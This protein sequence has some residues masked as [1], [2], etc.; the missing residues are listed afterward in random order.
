MRY[1]LLALT[2]VLA[3][4]ASANGEINVLTDLDTPFPPG[5]VAVSLPQQPAPGGDMLF[6][7]DIFVPSVDDQSPAARVRVNIWRTG[8][9]DAGYSVVMVRLAQ[10]QRWPGARAA[11]V[12]RGRHGGY[13]RAYR[14]APA[15]PGRG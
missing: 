12:R 11:P 5:C 10:D 13:P 1:L 8:C 2:F 4:H 15:A 14:P 6:N 3:G 7:E 9:H